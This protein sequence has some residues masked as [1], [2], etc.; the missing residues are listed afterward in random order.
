MRL[1]VIL[2]VL[3]VVGVI[4]AARVRTNSAVPLPA[5]DSSVTV[6]VVGMACVACAGRVEKLVRNMEGVRSATVKFETGEARIEYDS[7]KVTPAAF[8]TRISDAG[9]EAVVPE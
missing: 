1:I 3:C 4:V 9:F 5:A 7:A 2:A 6:K 8:A